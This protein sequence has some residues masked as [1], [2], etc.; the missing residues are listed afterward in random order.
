MF[1]KKTKRPT[2]FASDAEAVF[3]NDVL[4]VS[5]L[6]TLQIAGLPFLS[7]FFCEFENGACSTVFLHTRHTPTSGKA[8]LALG[9]LRAGSRLAYRWGVWW[10]FTMLCWRTLFCRYS[11]YCLLFVCCLVIIVFRFGGWCSGLLSCCLFEF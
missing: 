9:C 8:G 5:P 1:A 6:H 7:R 11:C 3:L 2:G 10:T 4:P